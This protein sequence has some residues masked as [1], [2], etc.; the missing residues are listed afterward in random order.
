MDVL[1]ESKLKIVDY[2]SQIKSKSKK[3]SE[4]LDTNMVLKTKIEQLEGKISNITAYSEWQE[5]QMQ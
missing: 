1:K 4:L 2:K 5:N 3:V